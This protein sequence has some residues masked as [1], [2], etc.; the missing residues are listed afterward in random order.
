M[1]TTQ[2]PREKRATQDQSY[3]TAKSVS[4]FLNVIIDDRESHATAD[5]SFWIPS[6]HQQLPGSKTTPITSPFYYMGYYATNNY[7][8]PPAGF[9]NIYQGN[10]GSESN[11]C[12]KAP[13]GFAEIWTCSGNGAPSYLGIYNP[14]APDG[15]IAIG[16]V[17]VMD[18]KWP[19]TVDQYP[20]LMC[21]RE[22]LVTQVTL[23]TTNNYVWADHNSKATQDVTVFQ[24]PNSQLCYAVSGYP[25]S[26][27]AWDIVL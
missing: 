10:D 13:T 18:F 24:L 12:F 9:C 21:V 15:Y 1:Q 6:I 27:T 7:T 2:A 14:I 22:D 19:P 25:S 3:L 16:T 20:G 23:N 11:P 8:T 4:T 17:A 5:I 26:V